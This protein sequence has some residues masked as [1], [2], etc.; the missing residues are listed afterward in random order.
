M[1]ATTNTGLGLASI[2][3]LNIAIDISRVEIKAKARCIIN[4]APT[5]HHQ[6]ALR[7]VGTIYTFGVGLLVVFAHKVAI[8]VLLKHIDLGRGKLARADPFVKEHIQLGKRAPRRLGHAEVG[9]YDAQKAYAGPEE[10]RKVTPVPGAG[11]QHVGC[12]GAANDA[13]DDASGKSAQAH[14]ANVWWGRG[15]LTKRRA[16]GRRS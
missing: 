1:K 14:G 9:V 10:A 15:G 5:Y 3:W 7:A 13:H 4:S 11:I 16:P 6:Q 12:D 8:N 2:S